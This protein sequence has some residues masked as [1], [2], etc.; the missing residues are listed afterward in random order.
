MTELAV[1]IFVT[2]LLMF[3]VVPL[4]SVSKPKSNRAV[5]NSHLHQFDM[6]IAT[7]ML[8]NAEVAPTNVTDC[9]AVAP[10]LFK[11]PIDP[12]RKPGMTIAQITTN[13]ALFS[14]YNYWPE[15]FSTNHTSLSNDRFTSCIAVCDKNGTNDANPTGFGGNH[16]GAGGNVLYNDHS[17]RWIQA[18]DWATNVWGV[19]NWADL[20]P[21]S[22]Y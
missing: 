11:C 4:F 14:S 20:G 18:K 2:A 19:T 8:D 3:M 22:K 1:V 21:I 16:A 9:P 6:A 5:C 10:T 7:Y 15:S 17:T 13:P 12:Y